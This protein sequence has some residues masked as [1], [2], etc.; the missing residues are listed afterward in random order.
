MLK[1][2]FARIEQALAP[3]SAAHG[4]W[5]DSIEHELELAAA[6]L[7]VEMTRADHEV[8]AVESEA[9]LAAV[10]ET[11]ELSAEEAD[12]LHQRAV[13]RAADAVSLYE[14]TRLLNDRLDDAGKEHVVELLWRVAAADGDIDSYEEH[15]VRQI[16]ELLYVPH[17]RFIRTKLRVL[18]NP[19][20]G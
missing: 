1:L 16:A 13:D 5:S 14:F 2:L 3:A 4:H 6:S 9:V 19:P 18:G 11:F 17:N 10:R 15:L 20:R 8:H 7:L 12:Q